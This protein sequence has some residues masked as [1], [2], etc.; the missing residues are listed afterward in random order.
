MNRTLYNK[1]EDCIKRF[2]AEIMPWGHLFRMAYRFFESFVTF[3]RILVTIKTTAP[4][5]NAEM[6]FRS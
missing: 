5:K 3:L 4:Q 1:H 6:Y 2:R